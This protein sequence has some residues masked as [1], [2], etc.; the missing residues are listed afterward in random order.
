MSDESVS[1]SMAAVIANND[2][3][4]VSERLPEEHQRVWIYRDKFHKKSGL[5]P[6]ERDYAWGSWYEHA[7]GEKLWSIN[8][9]SDFR[10]PTPSHWQP[11]PEPPQ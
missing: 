6:D 2:W 5:K 9:V 4:P 1:L 11:L 10:D 3:I 7:S 8:G